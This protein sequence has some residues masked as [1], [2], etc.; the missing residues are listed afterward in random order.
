[1]ISIT[2]PLLLYYIF[3]AANAVT[4][5][6]KRREGV[7]N[8]TCEGDFCFAVIYD[9]RSPGA[10]KDPVQKEQGCLIGKDAA[11]L[12]GR[13]LTDSANNTQ[14][15]CN[16]D[17]C[18][19]TASTTRTRGNV[20]CGTDKNCQFCAARLRSGEI[21]QFCGNVDIAVYSRRVG[22]PRPQS[23]S[24]HLDHNVLC[25]CDTGDNCAAQLMKEQTL[26]T[27]CVSVY[28]L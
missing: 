14:C 25:Y 2:V 19:D 7:M 17:F 13:C 16:T 9:G 20:T 10:T 28:N 21:Y 18:S 15:V 4:C 26:V 12:N 24:R 6:F 3:P 22:Y 8:R 27:D 1:R 23:C 5:R 11:H